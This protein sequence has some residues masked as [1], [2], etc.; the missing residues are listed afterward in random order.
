MIVVFFR[1]KV[2]AEKK[3]I[4]MAREMGPPVDCVVTAWS[5]WSE[6]NGSC[7]RT[8][9]RKFRMVKRY[10]SEGGK[11]CPRKLERKQKCKFPLPTSTLATGK[12]ILT[13]NNNGSHSNVFFSGRL[14]PCQED[15]LLGKWGEWSACSNS[16]GEDGT[17][18]R[19]REVI[20]QAEPE[21]RKCGAKV[22]RRF[23]LLSEC[24]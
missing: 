10:P 13:W 16:C 3:E 9:R 18:E 15:C 11:T 8:F 19:L 2:E 1:H 5:P 14:P 20:H 7:G 21:G 23:C 22:E 6:C 17:Q 24:P 4:Q 12:C